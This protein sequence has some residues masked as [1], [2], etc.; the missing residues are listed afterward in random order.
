MTV[1]KAHT[2]ND[3]LSPHVGYENTEIFFIILF[4]DLSTAQIY[5][6]AD[7]LYRVRLVAPWHYVALK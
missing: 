3:Y 7:R 6:L 5:K 2:H 4:W 1:V